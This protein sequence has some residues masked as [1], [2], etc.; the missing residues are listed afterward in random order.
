MLP[1]SCVCVCWFICRD[2]RLYIFY[3][4]SA[5]LFHVKIFPG[6]PQIF[7]PFGLCMCLALIIFPG[8]LSDHFPGQK[9]KQLFFIFQGFSSHLKRANALSVMCSQTWTLTNAANVGSLCFCTLMVAMAFSLWF[10]AVC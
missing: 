5:I 8:A 4:H 3:S 7:I 6:K 1:F 9:F 2:I 10:R